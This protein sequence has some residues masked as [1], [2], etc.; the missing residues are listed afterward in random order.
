MS[1]SKS[2]LNSGYNQL[3]PSG[4]GAGRT[5]TADS[6]MRQK[7]RSNVMPE[8]AQASGAGIQ[9]PTY[10]GVQASHL[11]VYAHDN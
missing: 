5:M 1:N 10:A 6:Y 9:A 4:N 11:G 7:Q 8:V 2:N 3:E